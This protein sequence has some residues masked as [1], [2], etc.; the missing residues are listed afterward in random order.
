[1]KNM[2]DYAA[3]HKISRIDLK[4]TED[5]YPIYKKMG[6]KDKVQ[7]YKEMRLIVAGQ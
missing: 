2:I 5:G 6:F 4:A 3:E 7:N 1:M